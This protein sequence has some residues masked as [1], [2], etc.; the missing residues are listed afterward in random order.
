MRVTRSAATTLLTAAVVGLS[1]SACGNSSGA[2]HPGSSSRSANASSSPAP[3]RGSTQ[4]IAWGFAAAYARYLD[5]QLPAAALPDATA[6]ARSQAG[7]RL[8]AAAHAGELAVASIQALPGQRSFVVG[9][10]D[11][12]HRFSAQLTVAPDHARWRVTQVLAPD[13]D[14]ILRSSAPIRLPPRSHAAS[15]AARQFLSG[16]LAWLFGQAPA[17]AIHDGTPPLVARLRAHPPRVPPTLRHV[18]LRLVAIGMQPVRGDW[19]AL[20]NVT[21][22]QQTYEL[23]LAVVRRGGR[24]LVNSVHTTS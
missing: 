13:L 10:S 8:P 1:L 21:D 22:G 2:D 17:I 5:G 6:A 24:W 23:T 3:P 14:S 11:R 12:A 15:G 20:A 9:F 16:Y 19:T 18:Q 4:R 7:A